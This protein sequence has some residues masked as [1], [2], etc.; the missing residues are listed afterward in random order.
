MVDAVTFIDYPG[1]TPEELSFPVNQRL[2][3]QW[4]YEHSTETIPDS[5]IK[6]RPSF[7]DVLSNPTKDHEHSIASNSPEELHRTL[8]EIFS[9][10]DPCFRSQD[11]HTPDLVLNLPI[12]HS[13][14]IIDVQPS[15]EPKKKIPPPVMKKSEKTRQLIQRLGLMSLSASPKVTEV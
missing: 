15:I 10:V 6:H 8:H 3:S 4:C 12:V 5:H 7:A 11:V 9:D 13:T 2:N 1:K 14:I